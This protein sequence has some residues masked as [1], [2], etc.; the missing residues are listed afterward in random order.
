MCRDLSIQ[1]EPLRG[2]I[3]KIMCVF[4]PLP[5]PLFKPL[6][7]NLCFHLFPFVLLQWPMYW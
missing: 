7:K 1:H 6:I 2:P 4:L 3:L 5:D